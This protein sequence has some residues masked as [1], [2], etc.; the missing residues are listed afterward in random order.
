AT[1]IDLALLVVA[2]DEGVMPQTREHVAILRHLGVRRGV[3]ALTKTDVAPEGEWQGLVIDDVSALIAEE[4]QAEWP[5]VPVSG[6]TGSGLDT[7]RAALREAAGSIP[8]RADDDRFRMP[9]DRVFAL[10]GAGTIVT[11]TVWSGRLAEGD[12]VTVLPAGRTVRVRSIQV[13][14][15]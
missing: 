14:G 9:V 5:I 12:V 4:M 8:V 3:V 7:L 1:G 2:A 13:H 6:T 10:A 15:E 11:G